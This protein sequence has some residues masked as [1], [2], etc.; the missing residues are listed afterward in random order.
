MKQTEPYSL[1]QNATEGTI[2]DL[3]RGSGR[4]M[5]K[6]RSPKRLRDHCLELEGIICSNTAH[7]IFKPKGE[8]AETAMTGNMSDISIIS[9]HA[10]YDWINFYNPV[11]KQFPE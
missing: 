8:V 2:I 7:D 4:K 5:T 10:W 3:K 11:S 1:C 9:D 6:S